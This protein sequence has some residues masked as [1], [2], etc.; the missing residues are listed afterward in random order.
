[1]GRAIEINPLVPD[2]YINRTVLSFGRA[3][4]DKSWRDVK[5]AR[6]LGAQLP[7]GFS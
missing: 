6:S 4:Y 3:E 5:K 2:P 7:P 1:L